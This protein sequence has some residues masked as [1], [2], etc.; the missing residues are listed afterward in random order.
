MISIIT[1]SYQQAKFLEATIQ[2]VLAQDYPRVEYIIIDG[3][4]T[5]GSVEIIQRYADRLAYWVSEPDQGQVDA[6]NKG[7]AR[8]Q[9]DILTWLNSDDTYLSSQVISQAVALFT[10]Y[11]QV[12]VIT[13]CGVMMDQHGKWLRPFS[14]DPARI[15]YPSLRCRNAILQPATFFRKSVLEKNPLDPGLHYA[16]DWD[17]WIRLARDVNILAVPHVW[18]GYRWWGENK[19]ARGASGRTREQVEVIRRYIGKASWQYWLMM[20]FY[21]TYRFAEMLPAGLER[22]LKAL[23]HGLSQTISELTH[24][25]IPVA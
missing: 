2:S 20:A 24:K 19:T 8:A 21:G 9:G 11:P 7:F 5:D 23:A 4:S 3:G 1:P 10:Q 6:L 17:F 14:V 12:D 13:G 15:S 16:F 25:H 18:A 22:P